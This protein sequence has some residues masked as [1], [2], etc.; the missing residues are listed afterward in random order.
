MTKK[1][2]FVIPFIHEYPAL[3]HTIFSIQAEMQDSPYQ[4]EISV[5]EN[6]T[7]DENTERWFTGSRAVFRDEMGKRIKYYFDPIQCYSEDTEVLTNH[8]WMYFS[9]LSGSEFIATLNSS[10][11]IL[12]YQKPTNYIKEKYQGKMFHQTSKS[13]DLMVTP[14]H[15]M[16]TDRAKDK[17]RKDHWSLSE[18]RNLPRSVRYK[19]NA[20][21]I[22]KEEEYFTLPHYHYEWDS[23]RNHKQHKVIDI[24]EK[25]ILM[26]DWLA[27]FG[28]WLA[29]GCT[30][31]DSNTIAI[32]QKPQTMIYE[33]IKELIERLP[34]KFSDKYYGFKCTDP[35]LSAY[36]G[37]FG[38][39]HGK[40]IPKEILSLS[41][42]QLKILFR[43]MMYGDGTKE[44]WRK[45]S[46][47]SKYLADDFQELLLKIGYAGT[48]SLDEDCGGF[49]ETDIYRIYIS[50]Q[51]LTPEVNR[52]IDGRKWIDYDGY[53]YCL[54][55]PN[56]LIYVR[57]N[58]KVC[59]CGNCGPHA[60]NTG[61]RAI[62]SDYTI[63]MDAHT[64]LG[65]NSII[66]LVE[67]LDDN[68]NAGLVSGLTSWST[69]W[70][71]R[72][73]SYYEL[74]LQPSQQETHKGGPT[75]DTHMHGH[76][77]AMGHLA[78]KYPKEYQEKKPMKVVM[79]SQAYTM[80]RTQDFLDIGGY[81]DACRFYPHPEG[82]M[83][84]K[85]WMS[86]KEV[87]IHPGSYHFHSLFPR[88]YSLNNEEANTKIQ[89]FGGYNW[90]E[91]GHMNIYKIAYILGEEKWT[92][93]C[94][95]SLKECGSRHDEDKLM[96]VAIEEAKPI[97]EQLSDKFI[98]SLD[99]IL[100]MARK[101]KIPGMEHWFKPIGNDPLG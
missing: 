8:G 17:R 56:H 9:D 35:Q 14:N 49:S 64:G 4:W 70:Y 91:H 45:Y 60:R 12:E 81:C 71:D 58:G 78:N 80:Y 11:N 27:F 28:I 88:K 62:P 46:T 69:Y 43:W 59:W 74:F 32:G 101:E 48:I 55:V 41:T 22:G 77:M 50:R 98:Y 6:G 25:K 86:G 87:Y 3:P 42:R 94:N 38:D 73:G 67:C 53:I 23:G 90:Q 36:L 61:A 19:R 18:A 20:V 76:Y 31:A 40:Y 2:N 95:T 24:P 65:K 66:P 57:R 89:E 10:T 52:T 37:L 68:P 93:I 15:L 82:Y 5:V 54:E 85:M 100:T 63:F 13:I 75:L 84:M 39:S 99:S 33:K 34:W 44:N 96:G 51:S 79:G 16:Y 7:V 83:P 1:I 92:K 47:V 29:E 30:F 97:R 72:L 26:D 21:W